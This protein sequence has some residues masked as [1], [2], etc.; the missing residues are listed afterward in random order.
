MFVNL[1]KGKQNPY[2]LLNNQEIID[3]SM[4][5]GDIDKYI[6]IGNKGTTPIITNKL[7]DDAT[8]CS[9]SIPIDPEDIK[10]YIKS[11]LSLSQAQ[12]Y[13]N[14]YDKL[15]SGVTI[16][17]CG[18][19]RPGA[20]SESAP[21]ASSPGPRTR[22]Y[23]LPEKQPS[24]SQEERDRAEAE[25]ELRKEEERKEII[26][27]KQREKR[28]IKKE[29]EKQIIKNRRKQL[30]GKFVEVANIIENIDKTKDVTWIKAL[31]SFNPNKDD[32]FRLYYEDGDKSGL[33][34]I[35]DQPRGRRSSG[36]PIM[37][38]T[39]YDPETDT[40]EDIKT[41]K[42]NLYYKDNIGK[43]IDDTE[44]ICKKELLDLH[45]KFI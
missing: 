12:I 41:I 30:N 16:Q 14:I 2:L 44:I 28:E 8:K 24:E 15:L 6:Y 27:E 39:K 5:N 17:V 23:S 33:I 38:F 1:P 18:N 32:E 45:T 22:R 31:I 34:T 11:N 9:D 37:I 13:K 35:N 3:S 10:T 29:E 42:L 43:K 4:T 40:E 21:V 7:R 19:K 26:R 20:S 25:A 36:I